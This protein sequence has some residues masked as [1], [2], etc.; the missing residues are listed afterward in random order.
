MDL[1]LTGKKV[2]VSGASRGIGLGIA[3]KF[4][5]E[6]AEVVINSRNE[7]KLKSTATSLKNCQGVTGD[8]SNEKEA[9]LVIK[10]TV[11]ILGRIDIVVCNVGSGSSVAPGE[12]TRNEWERV[13]SKNFS[14]LQT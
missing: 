10:K 14:V 8:V 3:S 4:I 2:F 1:N 11:E 9:D 5:E 13:F 7:E 12:E 6:G